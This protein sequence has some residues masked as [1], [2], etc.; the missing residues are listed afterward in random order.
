MIAEPLG[1]GLAMSGNAG[2]VSDALRVGGENQFLIYG[3]QLGWLGL[4]LYVLLLGFGIYYCIAVF[5]TSPY[6]SVARI[7]FVGGV[8]KFGLL[9][10]LFTANVE[11]YTYV[12]WLSWWMVGFSVRQYAI[13]HYQSPEHDSTQEMSAL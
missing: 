7:A 5:Y 4:L 9:L 13:L 2:S 10:P 11:I 8:V 12:S 1:I 6:K 3:V